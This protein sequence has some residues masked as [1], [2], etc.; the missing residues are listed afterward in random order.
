MTKN[1]GVRTGLEYKGTP[2]YPEETAVKLLRLME[3]VSLSP[4][5]PEFINQKLFKIE[6]DDFYSTISL[7]FV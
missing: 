5:F 4:E 7:Q 3:G 6:H 1:N 2:G